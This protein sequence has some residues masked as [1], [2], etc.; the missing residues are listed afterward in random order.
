MSKNCQ[1]SPLCSAGMLPQ[2][3]KPEHM[4]GLLYNFQEHLSAEFDA[5]KGFITS[6]IDLF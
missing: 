5:K 4:E 3:S 6:L 1:Y 2:K